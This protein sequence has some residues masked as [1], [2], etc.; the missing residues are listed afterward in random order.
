MRDRQPEVWE[1]VPPRNRNFTGREELLGRLRHKANTVT[2]VVPQPQA[3][4]GLGGVGKTHLAVEYAWRYRSHYDLVWWIPSDQ[5]VLVPSAL[6]AMAPH[7]GLP[8]A[9]ATG[10]EEA[11]DAVRRALESGEPYR[12]WL[13]I[14]DNAEEPGQIEEFIPRG[15]G[16]VLI[17]SR[18]PHWENHFETLQVDV[19]DR[20]E[21]LE[22]LRKRLHRDIP[23]KDSSV[24]ADRLGDL[25]LA[26]EQAG[27]LQ[28]ETG[29]A[30]DEYIEQ[31]DRQTRNLLS[32]NRA[33]GYPMSMTAA[34]RVSVSL[35]EDRLPEAIKVLRCCAFFGPEP[36]PRDVF[37]RGNQVLLREDGPGASQLAAVLSDPIMLSK[38]LGELRRFALARID[39][40]TRTI[41]VHRL[42]QA[43]LRDDLP[44]EER[45][46][47]RHEVHLLLAG[48]APASPE[49]TGKWS[50]F[51]ELVAHII[52]S[53]LA[54]CTDPRVREFALNS[55]RYLYQAGS[56]QP[57]LGFVDEFIGRWT[58]ADG[59]RHKDVLVA[60]VHR[61]NILR[62]L[63]R[64]TEDYE[65]TGKT[66][67]EM[68]DALGPEHPETLWAAAGYGGS[69]RARGEFLPARELDEETLAAHE[70]LFGR[71][72]PMT[73]RA[74]HNFALDYALTSDYARSRDLH[75][76]A[77]RGQSNVRE[78]VSENA[79]LLSLNGLARSV[80]L[81]G[82]YKEACDLGDEAYEY[83][84]QRL[85]PD[86]PT[87]LH[88][89]RDLSI[90]RRRAGN[91]AE[92]LELARE[93][94]VR[95]KRILG[96]GHPD[97]MAA[98]IN[99]SNTLRTAGET[100]EAFM[101]AEG[102]VRRYPEVFGE[103]HPFT[104]ACRINLAI[105]YRLRGDADR[106]RT[107]D[108]AA[109]ERLAAQLSRRHHYSLTCAVNLATD[110]ATLGEPA[111]AREIGEET[112]ERLRKVFGP[113]HHLTLICTSNLILDLRAVGADE[114]ADLLHSDTRR[115]FDPPGGSATDPPD[116]VAV[117][118]GRR[119]DCD[120]D[121]PP[122]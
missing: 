62:G 47:A 68:R 71:E 25:P 27:A 74:L 117:Y 29:M 90:A 30:I 76:D 79:F 48:A 86:H 5:R 103:E 84:L 92:A 49:T 72:N 32:A 112:L 13:L 93:T 106:A 57:A 67:R 94:H 64:Y 19:F 80:R 14:F 65:S 99:V 8:P 44:E 46:K 31:L 81:S 18:N 33:P 3:L 59:P 96:D 51:N 2:A 115:R 15:P 78:G 82:D 73:L 101:I 24:L 45:A 6:A 113:D 58:A 91:L 12:K 9:S 37:R 119:V 39:P 38:T 4:Q 77:Y 118:E 88:A 107:I 26:L 98:A 97:T 61:G 114:E 10:V 63:G 23:A 69:L 40:E 34:W 60:R 52:P 75:R 104:H 66:L 95:L 108:E 105:L 89:A 121:P 56:Y 20:E 28:Y 87:T 116:L 111:R 17:T 36:I 55:V 21:S 7:L 11:A 41:Q 43:L 1:K 122:I 42:V 54:E 35:L 109:L 16:H 70:R 100:D 85:S 110:L 22:F 120:F 83:G 53:G 102:T 50:E